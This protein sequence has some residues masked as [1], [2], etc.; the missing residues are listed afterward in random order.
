MAGAGLKFTV[1]V[2]PN[3]GEDFPQGLSP[4]ETA[5]YIAN[6]KADA[7]TQG[8]GDNDVVITA[9]TIVVAKGQVLG[10]PKNDAD[11]KRML[12]LLSG[13]THQVVTGVT[14]STTNE[15]RTFSVATDVTFR[16]LSDEEIDYYVDNFHPLDK[17]G[18]YGIQEWIGYIGVSGISGSYYNVMGLPIQRVYSE[19]KSLKLL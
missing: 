9:D 15:R 11:A 17:A 3:V 4:M 5:K 8:I 6:E 10:K 16:Q 19:L 13:I 14:I 1:K 2:K 12:R 18:A 7:N